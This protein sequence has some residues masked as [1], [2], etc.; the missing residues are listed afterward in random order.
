[1]QLPQWLL[2]VVGSTQA[3]SQQYELD[4]GPPHAAPVPHM[5]VAPTQVLPLSQAGVH[6]VA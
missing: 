3:P 4:H 6:P 5:Q 2:S 1:M